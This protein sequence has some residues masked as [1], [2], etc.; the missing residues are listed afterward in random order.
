MGL[1]NIKQNYI[2]MKF[3][4]II[5]FIIANVVLCEPNQAQLEREQRVMN[6]QFVGMIRQ[7]G[8]NGA[9]A[10]N[11]NSRLNCS[12][13]VLDFIT[14]QKFALQNFRNA[15]NFTSI[16]ESLSENKGFVIS[17]NGAQ[18]TAESLPIPYEVRR[19]LGF[20][21]R[22]RQGTLQCSFKFNVEQKKVLEENVEYILNLS[23]ND[24]KCA[25]GEN[26]EESVAQGVNRC[27]GGKLGRNILRELSQY[28]VNI[29]KK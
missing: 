29:L 26:G 24:M 8:N 2:T 10:I 19:R 1:S 7:V 22:S 9:E 21:G 5:S 13:G 6:E 17:A 27:L 16:S 28:L 18:F 23:Y 20:L 11:F 25:T 14:F 3:I 4:L 15:S 12:S